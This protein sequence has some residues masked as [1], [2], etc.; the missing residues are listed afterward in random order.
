MHTVTAQMLHKF[1]TRV[2]KARTLQSN[3]HG[4]SAEIEPVRLKRAPRNSHAICATTADKVRGW[5]Y[6]VETTCRGG[7]KSRVTQRCSWVQFQAVPS[8]PPYRR[9]TACD[10]QTLVLELVS[11]HAS[12]KLSSVDVRRPCISDNS[13][14]KPPNPKS[15]SR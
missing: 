2:R 14:L 15:R 5:R 9:S 6:S 11:R 7:G 8:T 12:P 13:W 10:Y 4:D 3:A 1:T